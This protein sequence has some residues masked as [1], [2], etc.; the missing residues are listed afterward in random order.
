MVKTF[1]FWYN[2]VRMYKY[3]IHFILFFL[4]SWL[5]GCLLTET[6]PAAGNIFYLDPGTGT[7]TGDGSINHPWP[8]LQE[9]IEAGL[10]RT[11]AYADHPWDAEDRL[12]LRNPEG[13]VHAGDTLRLLSGDHGEIE[14][15]ECYNLRYLAIEAES[16]AQPFCSRLEIA[17]ASGISIRGMTVRPDPGYSAA[18]TLIQVTSHNWQGPAREIII[19]D[20]YIYSVE[21]STSWGLEEWNTLAWSGIGAAGDCITIRNNTLLNVNFGISYTGNNGV[22]SG[23]SVSNFSGDGLRGIGNDLLFENNL[24]QDNYNI[25]E[26]HDDGFQS[27]SLARY[28]QPPR[29]RVTLRGNTIINCTDP[30]RPFQGGLQG[31]GC[32]DGFFIDWVV[33]NNLILVDHWHGITFLGAVNTRIVN[34]TV[35]DTR[36]DSPGPSWIMV[37]SH[38]DGR[39]SR[40]C[41][42]QNNI[43]HSISLSPGAGGAKDNLLIHDLECLD[44]LFTDPRNN[45]F[46]LK[47]N[48]AAVDAGSLVNAPLIDKNGTLRPRGKGVDIGA[49]ENF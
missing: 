12:Y 10:I 16:G 7:L 43:A 39:P 31:I 3:I 9:V 37:G 4:L 14:L 46:Q 5:G 11:Y 20:C 32:F 42:I 27:W 48:S 26:N 8:S 22:V 29:E 45:G 36:G 23:N 35:V 25:N 6:D 44:D 1:T 47:K 24:V 33:E 17:A 40:D 28:D 38:K 15:R 34:N 19:E 30:D 49:F 13:P 21:D 41:L 2:R 18:G